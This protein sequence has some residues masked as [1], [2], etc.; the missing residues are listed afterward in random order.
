MSGPRPR[1]R[2][3]CCRLSLRLVNPNRHSQSSKGRRRGSSSSPSWGGGG[4]GGPPPPPRGGA[5]GGGGGGAPPPRPRESQTTGSPDRGTAANRAESPRRDGPSRDARERGRTDAAAETGRTTGGSEE[6]ADRQANGETGTPTRHDKPI[7]AQER[8][9]TEDGTGPEPRPAPGT[10]E[11]PPRPP[12]TRPPPGPGDG[13]PATNQNGVTTQAS[14][15]KTTKRNRHRRPTATFYT[16]TPKRVY[17]SFLGTR[18][19]DAGV[20]LH[21]GGHHKRNSPHPG[22]RLRFATLSTGP[23]LR[24]VSLPESPHHAPRAF[25]PPA[26]QA[27]A[28]RDYPYPCP[29]LRGQQPRQPP[30]EEYQKPAARH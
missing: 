23:R 26:A 4:G 7:T 11:T 17:L 14:D 19:Q 16:H 29:G 18:D 6:P 8:A 1:R 25:S 12:E 2:S 3:S 27:S 22:S 24:T 15:E 21:A 13:N 20:L 9:A 5:A 30:G 10:A 28:R